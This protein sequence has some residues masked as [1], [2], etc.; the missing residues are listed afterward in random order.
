METKFPNIDEE[1][2]KRDM[3]YRDLASELNMP[4]MNLYRRLTGL[5]QW[6]LPE[7]V[8]VCEFFG[9]DDALT[10]FTIR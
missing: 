1:L 9:R 5:T 7:V 3:T 2:R 4:P 10:L 8:V 6:S